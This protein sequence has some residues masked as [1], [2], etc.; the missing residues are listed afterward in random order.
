MLIDSGFRCHLTSF[1]RT[2]AAAPSPFVSKLR[3]TLKTRR[4]TSVSQVGTDR[5]IEFQFSD[6]LYRLY[7]E[8][9]AAGNIVLTDKDLN[10]LTFL[11]RV[12]DGAEHERVNIG[13]TYNLD[14]RQN[15]GGVPD[16]TKERIRDGLQKAI[17]KQQNAPEAPQQRKS[18]K[19]G[20]DSL[21]KALAVSINEYPPVLVDHAFTE[22]KFDP[23]TLPEDVVKSEELLDKLLDVLQEAKKVVAEITGSEVVKGYIIAKPKPSSSKEAGPSEEKMDAG[24]IYD[25]FHPFRPKQFADDPNLTILEFDGYNKTTDEFFSSIEGQKLESRLT[26]REEAAKKKLEETRRQHEQRV[27]GLQQVQEL[28]VRKAEAISANV[29]RVEEAIAAVN[30]LLGQGMDWADIARLI[31]SEQGRGNAVAQL[32]KLP[33]KLY[34][35]TVT[36]LLGEAEADDELDSGYYGS[37][38]ESQSESDE[39]D[40]GQQLQKQEDKRLAIDIDLNLSAWANASQYYDQKKT[41]AE[42]KEKTLQASTKA[43]KSAAQKI[44]A[45]LKKDLNQE[46]DVLRPVRKQFWFEKFLYFISS[47]GYL[48]IG[49][50]DAQ[51]NELLYRRYLKKGDVYVHADMKGAPSVIIKNNPSTPDA[52]IPPS[53][54]SQAGNLAVCG[55]DAWESKTVIGAYWV[56]AD[57]VSKTAPTGEYITT[58]AFMIRGTKNFLPP[59]QL[60]MGFA[61]AWEISEDSKARHVR[62]RL[63]DNNL[64][65]SIGSLETGAADDADAPQIE[66]G[67]QDETEDTDEDFPDAKPTE[68]SDEDFPDAKPTAV[69]DNEDED[70]DARPAHNPLQSNPSP[71]GQRED[72]TMSGAN[73]EESESSKVASQGYVSTR[74]RRLLNKGEDSVALMET[75]AAEGQAEDSL[76]EAPSGTSTPKPKRQQLPRGKRTK[77]KKAAAKYADQDEEDRELALRLVGAKGGKEAKDA[78]A[79]AK[80]AKEEEERKNKERRRQQHIKKLAD[81]ERKRT[82]GAE[83]DDDEVDEE[84]ESVWNNELNALDSLVGKPLPGDELMAAIPICAPWTALSNYKY[85]VKLQ[86]GATKKGKA[87]REILNKWNFDAKSPKSVDEKA[88]D[89]ERMWPREIELIKGIKEPEAIAVVPLKSC[90]VMMSGGAAGG[91]GKG[92]KGKGKARGGRGSKKQR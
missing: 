72:F 66:R 27:G 41:A 92:P 86:P 55:S 82:A 88:E 21:R 1:I 35:S 84:Q 14:M 43:L 46:K 44:A 52:P 81:E 30:G 11:R 57:Q 9:Y 15:Y 49:G 58:G 67:P 42:K 13:S 25:D 76:D 62:H 3:K 17:E 6:G 56:K 59:A 12:D 74:E 26:E 29:A 69:S 37:D 90:K 61:L 89:T 70:E 22:K 64:D 53:T 85:K 48:V 60:L 54:L 91:G 7:F 77:A 4:V 39:E 45:D 10:V 68:D 75:K 2:T 20:K 16:L 19:K 28:N 40:E 87:I 36:L 50:K 5:I 63:Q 33:M 34:E 8:F 23:S 18:K 73:P 80:K 83:G 78:E 32:I 38:T 31:E 47:D 71:E 51:Q 79:A 65:S 24:F